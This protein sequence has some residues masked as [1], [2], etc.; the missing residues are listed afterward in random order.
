MIR[1]AIVVVLS[2]CELIASVPKGKRAPPDAAID[3]GVDAAADAEVDAM[4]LSGPEPASAT[5][6]PAP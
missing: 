5:R 2:G 1:I 3:A 6:S 4:M